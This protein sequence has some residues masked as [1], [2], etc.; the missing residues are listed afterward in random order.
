LAPAPRE[1]RALHKIALALAAQRVVMGGRRLIGQGPIAFCRRDG[2]RWK[3][4]L[5]EGIDFS[6]FLLGASSER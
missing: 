1:S 2:L 3:L 4:D 5:R 6:I